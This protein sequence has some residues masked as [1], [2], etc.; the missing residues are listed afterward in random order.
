MARGLD[1]ARPARCAAA[2]RRPSGTPCTR[3][4]R[5]SGGHRPPAIFNG[6]SGPV[7]GGLHGTVANHHIDLRS[8]SRTM[9]IPEGCSNV[10]GGRWPPEMRRKIERVPEGRREMARWHA[11]WTS[12]A[13]PMRRGLHASLRDAGTNGDRHP[14]ATGPRLFS[15][16]PP[17]PCAAAFMRPS[18]DAGTNGDRHPGATGPRLFSMG[19][20]G[21]CAAAFRRPSRDAGTNGDTDPGATGPRLFSMGPPGPNA[22]GCTAQGSRYQ[23]IPNADT[24]EAQRWRQVGFPQHHSSRRDAGT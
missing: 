10:A 18:R 6:P 1:V 19:P 23:D 21:P 11:G 20:P 3:G 8:V 15:M 16:G 4:D 9:C 14:G 13:R 22:T 17:G 24:R 7:R 2:F 12:R 5:T